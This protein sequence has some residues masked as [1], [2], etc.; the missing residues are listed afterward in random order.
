MA[1]RHLLAAACLSLGSLTGCRVDVPNVADYADGGS[2]TGTSQGPELGS[3]STSGG[4][5]PDT[6]GLDSSGAVSA[7]ASG[8][9]SGSGSTGPHDTTTSGDTDSDTET[10]GEPVTGHPGSALVNAGVASASPSYS[11]IWTFGQSSQVQNT[12]TSPSYR[13]RGGVVA[14]VADE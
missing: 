7:S 11:M 8:S 3:S 2:T 1:S 12:M 14:A 4:V 5:D 10:G 9:A 6:L 13:I